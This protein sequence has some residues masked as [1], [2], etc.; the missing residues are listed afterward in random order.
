V[1][2]PLCPPP[3]KLKAHDLQEGGMTMNWCENIKDAAE[4]TNS[5]AD[6]FINKIITNNES[7]GIQHFKTF[8]VSRPTPTLHRLQ[9]HSRR[10]RTNRPPKTLPLGDQPTSRMIVTS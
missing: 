5:D 10:V 2:I 9:P 7:K 6:N 4:R 8:Q 1:V 3:P